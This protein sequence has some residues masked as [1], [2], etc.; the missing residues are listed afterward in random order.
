MSTRSALNVWMRNDNQIHDHIASTTYRHC[1]GYP[2]G[3]GADL[4]R[5]IKQSS[6]SPDSL[7]AAIPARLWDEHGRKGLNIYAAPASL[8][9]SEVWGDIEWIY[10]L[11]IRPRGAF[12][13][14]VQHRPGCGETWRQWFKGTEQEFR[15]AVARE[16]RAMRK[17][18]QAYL[19]RAG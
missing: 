14:V 7:A 19:R 8:D 15:Y 1:D 3:M 11:Y 17:R 5:Y 9:P 18:I 4:C 6:K 16:V 10:H 13:I 2:A 12:E